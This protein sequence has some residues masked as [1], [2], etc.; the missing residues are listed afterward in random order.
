M[1]NSKISENWI[2]KMFIFMWFDWKLE[3]KNWTGG[4]GERT[5]SRTSAVSVGW[6]GKDGGRGQTTCSTNWICRL[7]PPTEFFRSDFQVEVVALYG[8]SGS[9]SFRLSGSLNLPAAIAPPHNLNS[10][11][12]NLVFYSMFLNSNF[13]LF[14][15]FFDI[16]CGLLLYSIFLGILPSNHPDQIN[17]FKLRVFCPSNFHSLLRQN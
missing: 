8:W 6:S 11:Y 7:P 12:L 3:D 4:G 9:V 13:L 5:A 2:R 14:D 15:V 1:P 16:F 10:I 17:H